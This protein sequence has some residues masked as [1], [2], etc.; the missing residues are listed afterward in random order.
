MTLG[1]RTPDY[2][3][4]E[5]KKVDEKSDRKYIQN[6]VSLSLPNDALWA[7]PSRDMSY[8]IFPKLSFFRRS[9]AVANGEM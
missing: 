2:F 5:K 8:L 6:P 9:R 1:L 4:L 3:F 7:V